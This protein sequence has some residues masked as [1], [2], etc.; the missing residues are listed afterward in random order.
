M[1]ITN[2]NFC[3]NGVKNAIIPPD[4]AVISIFQYMSNVSIDFINNIKMP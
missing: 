1:L 2:F 4:S 3:T